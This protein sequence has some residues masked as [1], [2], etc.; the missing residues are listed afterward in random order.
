MMKVPI[1]Y[2]PLSR[3]PSAHHWRPRLFRSF[4]PVSSDPVS[5]PP[6][7]SVTERVLLLTPPDAPAAE[8]PDVLRAT[9][10]PCEPFTTLSPL[11][12][13]LQEGAGALIVD[14][15]A[16]TDQA[17]RLLAS[18]MAQREP[19]SNLPIIILTDGTP[20]AIERLDQLDLF[21][22]ASSSNVTI[23]ERPVHE[24][25]LKTVVRS[26]L[27]ARRRQY[28]V[29]DLMQNLQATNERLRESQAA[30]QA[31]NETLEE[32]VAARTE[33]VQELALALTTAEQ[34]ERARISEILHDH[35]QQLIH[36]AR[37][38]A[39]T[40]TRDPNEAPA[41]AA[42]RILDLLDEALDTTRSLTVELSPPVLQEEGL[43]EALD[44][45]ADHVAETHGLQLHTDVP[46]DLRVAE[47]DLRT[48]L[49]RSARELVFNVV[50]HA[51]VDTA[52]LRAAQAEGRFVIE[53]E[54]EGT[55]FDPEQL[56]E[57]GDP[58]AH[59]GLFSVRKRLDLVG[60]RLSLDSAPGEG[61]QA[62]IEVPLPE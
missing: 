19:W 14:E 5:S 57:A 52:S 51:E 17:A 58:D 39:D 32:R 25:T 10:V 22:P 35:L 54:D 1:F 33:Q 56:D 43:P 26:A 44:W 36:G 20:D 11:V 31:A 24:V 49:F 28:E 47:A 34:R 48:L 30:L 60:G 42:D 12:E 50:K 27:R 41:E 38:W 23:L 16:I 9:E 3:C 6:Q 62:R 8:I 4:M 61:T 46:A 18:A 15:D 45:L 37:I 13:T 59:F 40:L 53:V 7:S 21:G 29:R 55:G 2:R